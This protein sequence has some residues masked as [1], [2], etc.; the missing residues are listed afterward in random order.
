MPTKGSYAFF[1]SEPA[2][3]RRALLSWYR[4]R[5][6]ALPWREHWQRTG[7]PYGVWVSEIMLQQTLIKVVIPVYLR[8]MKRFPTLQD[9]AQATD[10]EVRQ[11][12]RGLGY[13][14]RFGFLHQAARQLAGSTQAGLAVIWPTSQEQWLT[15]PG[16]GTYTASA[17]ASICLGEAFP[18]LD[19]NV[20]RVLCRRLDLREPIG[21]PTLKKKLLPIAAALLDRACPGDF[22]QAMMELGQLVCTKANPKCGE[23][24]VSE[25]C[26]ALDKRSQGLS[27]AAKLRREATV[28]AL[29]L[30]VVLRRQGEGSDADV[31]VLLTRRDRG[32]R[33]LKDSWGFS[34]NGPPVPRPLGELPVSLGSFTHSITHHKITVDV[35][36][37]RV[38]GQSHGA[39]G[40]GA[41]GDHELQ[42]WVSLREVERQLVANL[43]RK[44][45]RIFEKHLSRNAKRRTRE[46]SS[47][48]VL[49]HGPH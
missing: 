29:K 30:W 40:A 47:P 7:D 20:E 15:L 33:F 5:D 28:V 9:L 16:I 31:Q 46:Q 11:E 24:P 36:L 14:R 10:D 44:A 37:V 21:T 22:N 18:V 12:V 32:S 23:C 38:K 27:P 34:E 17:L 48:F 3:F 2:P 13:Y 8:F 45:W 39:V 4:A 25:G 19:G 41:D 35:E 49:L 43:D 6:R 26:L 42:R 1:V